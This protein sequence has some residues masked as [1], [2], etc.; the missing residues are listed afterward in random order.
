MR[1]AIRFFVSDL[2]KLFQWSEA[3]QELTWYDGQ[4]VVF[5]QELLPLLVKLQQGRHCASI[6][7]TAILFAA[8][9]SSWAR[10][11][12]RLTRLLLH[13]LKCPLEAVRRELSA[14][15]RVLEEWAGALRRLDLIR[16]F[17]E[18]ERS[19]S[20]DFTDLL[21]MIL[22][23]CPTDY[24]EVEA[25]SLVNDFRRDFLREWPGKSSSHGKWI[26]EA[27][28]QLTGPAP[29]PDRLLT[30]CPDI[31][32]LV[33]LA[34]S[35][36]RAIPG[37]TVD[38]LFSAVRTGIRDA[39]AVRPIPE[40]LREPED[41]Q[42]GM[43]RLLRELETARRF[44]GL[45][46]LSGRIVA[47]LSL[48]RQL[49]EPDSLQ[50]GGVSDISNRG[51]IEKLLLSE[52]VHDD[53][54]LSVRLALNEAL[55]LRRESPPA[56][57][58]RTR[59]VLIDSSLPMWGLP[60]LYATAVAL[61]L[62]LTG[63]RQTSLRCFRTEH[64]RLVA[65]PLDSL[66]AVSEH[67]EALGS[68][69]APTELLAGF[70][71]RV[72]EQQPAAEPVL[73]TTGD[74][75]QMS[76]FR[77][78][79]DGL[80]LQTLWLI[81]VDRSGELE[82]LKKTRQGFSSLRRV[83]LP[84]SDILSEAEAEVL[85]RDERAD[86]LPAVFHRRHF[87]L[88]LSIRFER[89]RV[90]SWGP[91]V[92]AIAEGGRLMLWSGGQKGARELVR[93]AVSSSHQFFLLHRDLD[94][95]CLL[96]A[97]QGSTAGRLIRIHLADLSV[98][99]QAVDHGVFEIT[100][101][102]QGDDG[103]LIFGHD[104]NGRRICCQPA[105]LEGGGAG[106]T[107]A[108]TVVRLPDDVIQRLGRVLK[109]R[110]GSFHVLSVVQ[111]GS[112]CALQKLPDVFQQSDEVVEF[113]MGHYAALRAGQLWSGTGQPGRAPL[114]GKLPGLIQG[115]E[116]VSD[117]GLVAVRVEGTRGLAIIDLLEDSLVAADF[118]R[119][120]ALEMQIL[121]HLTATFRMRTKLWY[122]AVGTD[123]RAIFLLTSAGQ[124]DVI[125]ID[126]IP[127]GGFSVRLSASKA[128]VKVRM[129]DF[130]RSQPG[131]AAERGLWK[132]EWLSGGTIWLD[133]RGLLHLRSAN[134]E[135]AEVTLVLARGSFAGWTSAGVIFGDTEYFEPTS[136]LNSA[137]QG[138]RQQESVVVW[139]T[140]IIPLLES[141]L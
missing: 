81:L 108:P 77:S 28:S 51:S 109:L 43:R 84:L 114:A 41:Q 111:Y 136:G 90:W 35:V 70:V 89:R 82:I 65:C 34:I 112:I 48:P 127:R 58:K 29:D 31:L 61:A 139:R 117:D 132:A 74:V 141:L 46:R 94:V 133:P 37:S 99:I 104:E 62:H 7:A 103:A 21:T 30:A 9:R 22:R 32:Q 96:S 56:Q 52:L 44:R 137:T 131:L 39:A 116:E 2:P 126:E 57:D 134:P 123:E 138:L 115:I 92:V 76:S 11:S 24:S 67:L 128:S 38:E 25:E 121:R 26:E 50:L 86:D 135:H 118:R 12:Q 102:S 42:S 68:Q 129:R 88:L 4:T 106:S 6:G 83:L 113:A 72:D 66:A 45:A 15:P 71:E 18:D 54:T 69:A 3:G 59:S 100:D 140:V 78:R 107:F 110:D 101:V 63:D 119:R 36:S 23:G 5:R 85:Q 60:R 40:P 98:A 73:I 80:D 20:E 87:P 97:E 14:D 55:Y 49:A 27:I 91:D 122:T 120:P 1:T 75:L 10:I 79:L 105:W 8:R 124:I 125:Q 33:R 19:R 95:L 53:L 64:T 16:L 93:L 17:A 130:N 47:A 13:L